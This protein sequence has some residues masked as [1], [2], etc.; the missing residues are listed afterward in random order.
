M[1]K[2]FDKTNITNTKQF[3][4]ALSSVFTAIQGRHIQIQELLI[5]GL[6]QSVKGGNLGWVSDI[7]KLALNT[8]GINSKR[9]YTYIKEY[10]YGGT[11]TFDVKKE[12]FKKS[13]KAEEIIYN[14]SVVATWYDFDKSGKKE[15]KEIDYLERISKSIVN[16]KD[17]KK[18]HHSQADIIKTILKSGIELDGL[19][20]ILNAMV[21]E[22]K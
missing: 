20:D 5:L 10:M 2:S 7:Y 6:E 1:L 22:E 8:K 18:G 12:V 16:A 17:D 21:K 4:T 11:I 9:M 19:L 15:K 13:V 3:N 14:T